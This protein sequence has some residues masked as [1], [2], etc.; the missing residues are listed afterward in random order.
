MCVSGGCVVVSGGERSGGGCVC[1]GEGG[2]E[3]RVSE[4][5]KVDMPD[6]GSQT[7]SGLKSFF[8][9]LTL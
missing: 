8:P 4:T 1:G 5:S 2:R 3:G 7:E 6:A 9:L